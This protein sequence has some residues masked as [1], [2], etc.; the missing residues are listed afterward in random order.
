MNNSVIL[1]GKDRMKFLCFC[2]HLHENIKGKR[3][4]KKKKPRRMFS[5][6]KTHIFKNEHEKKKIE[7]EDAVLENDVNLEV[8]SAVCALQVSGRQEVSTKYFA[9]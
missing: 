7:N 1:Q 8:A 3:K 6:T 9:D 4:K 5:R 2:I